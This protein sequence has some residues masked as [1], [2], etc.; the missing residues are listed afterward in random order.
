MTSRF[1]GLVV[2]PGRHITHI[3]LEETPQQ[4]RVRDALRKTQGIA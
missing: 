2:V 3:E 1:I 4:G